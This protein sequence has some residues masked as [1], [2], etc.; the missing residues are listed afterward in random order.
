M[1]PRKRRANGKQ[2]SGADKP[3]ELPSA[4]SDREEAAA[5]RTRLAALADEQ[6][7]LRE[8][9][10]EIGAHHANDH[11]PPLGAAHVTASSPPA[12]KIAL[13][14]SLFRGREDV[15]PRRWTNARSGPGGLRT[16][17]RQR[18]GAAHLQQASDQV[19]GVPAPR[20][21]TGDR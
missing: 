19:S 14:R 8:R 13:F 15:F 11:G 1:M 9:L 6:A 18:M 17:L 4:I 21:H 7:A 3:M 10:A 16:R 12:E 5:I 20:L 2:R